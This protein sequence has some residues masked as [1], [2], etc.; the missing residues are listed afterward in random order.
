VRIWFQNEG[1]KLVLGDNIASAAPKRGKRGHPTSVKSW[2][3]KSVCGSIFADRVSEV[4]LRLSGNGESKDIGQYSR[5]LDD[6]FGKL[7]KDEVAQCTALAEQWNADVPSE[8][9]QR[10]YD[11]IHTSGEYF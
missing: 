9:I 10:K 1:P 2:T 5:A 11:N 4:H 7:S 8:D 6:I 3:P